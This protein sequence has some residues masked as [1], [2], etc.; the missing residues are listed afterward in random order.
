MDILAYIKKLLPSFNKNKIIESCEMSLNSIRE[1]TLPAYL[2]A[3]ETFKGPKF[4]SVTAQEY[5]VV[6]G[7]NVGKANGTAIIG[8]IR[9]RLE[10][11]LVILTYISAN[12][13]TIY[14]DVEANVAL[15]YTKA[16]FLRLIESAEFANT[17]A[18]K[19]LNYLLIL[20]TVELD[21]SITLG[22]SIA[23]AEIEWLDSGFLDF[24]VCVSVLG[25]DLKQ[26][27]KQI[28]EMPE[29]G[30]TELTERT[31]STTI[32]SSKMDPFRQRQLSAKV[33]PFYYFGM[34]TAE[35][36]AARYKA[37]K[38]ELE[39][40]QL[41]RLNLERMY[42]NSPDAKLQKEIE[43]MENRVSSANY[44]VAKMEEEY[45]NA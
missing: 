2:A 29:A 16:T 9:E 32:G 45:L 19:F 15:T 31:F 21:K 28:A 26:L 38:D 3:Q 36:Q 43:Y 42:N 4:K 13:K 39:L 24:C 44:R 18:R 37:A 17:F 1:H 7:K 40:L 14:S 6:Y 5:A 8:S 23:P 11:T 10:N 22:D 27:E 35:R 41:R 12:A 20:E 34:I 25:Q 30:I 33:N